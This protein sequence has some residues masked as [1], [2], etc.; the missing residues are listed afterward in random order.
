[1]SSLVI[2]AATVNDIP[3]IIMIRRD[4]LTAEELHGFS[5]DESAIYSSTE[6]LTENWKEENRLADGFCIYLAENEGNVVGFIVF[7]VE[8]NYGYIDNVVVA[9]K[10]QGNGVGT[11][12]VT[13][14]EDLTQAQGYSIMKTDTTEN[15]K[16]IPWKAYSF[17]IVLG[18]EDTGERIATNYDFKEIPLE[19]QFIDR[20]PG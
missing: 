1:M 12:L 16:G 5:A 17:W 19:K 6:K 8:N 3:A 7:K 11:A 18:Y 4:T 13:H 2:R 9:K 20:L 10:A 14:V 15:A